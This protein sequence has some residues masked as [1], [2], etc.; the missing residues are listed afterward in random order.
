[1]PDSEGRGKAAAGQ[2]RAA[3]RGFIWSIL[4]HIPLIL[5]VV[6]AHILKV[7]V[8]SRYLDLRSDVTI[9]VLRSLLQRSKPRSIS[10]SQALTLLDPGIKGRIWVS[11]VVSQVPP[12]EDIRDALLAAIDAMHHDTGADGAG[13]KSLGIVPVEAE[14]TGYRA[15]ATPES[16]L[17]Q[18]SENDKY[19]EMMKECKSPV[20]VLYFHGGAYYLCDP[21]SHRPMTKKLAK[22]TGGRV[23]SVRYRLAPQAPFPSALLDA[24]VSYFTLLYPGPASVHDAVAPEEIVFAGDSAGGN[25]ALALLQA[26]LEIRRQG[27]KITWFGEERDVPIP[28]GVAVNSPWV[29]LLQ[30]MPSLSANLKWDYLPPPA[31]LSSSWQPPADDI[32]PSDPPRRHIYVDDAH[33]LHPLVSLQLGRTWSGAPPVYI[34]C[35]WECLADEDRY[36][37]AKLRRDG[38]PVVF[39]EYEAMPHVFAA[40]LPKLRESRR[41]LEGWARFISDAVAVAAAAAGGTPVKSTYTTIQAKTL[42]EV[43]IDP[44]S[45]SPFSEEDV[46]D[47]AYKQVGRKRSYPEVVAKL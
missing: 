15:A 39:E 29:D 44:E 18:V 5:G 1:M 37:A 36:L 41:C 22:L 19:H 30:S 13:F 25:L 32:W 33:L 11:K 28:A 4:P 24:L 20:T 27:R 40:V 38:V 42:K 12:E 45:L 14:W 3:Q 7:S 9:T 8:Q 17:P 23:Y 34:C 46:V 10:Q 47:M 31:L 26:V 43:P 35:G 2:L 6:V 21:C 16:T